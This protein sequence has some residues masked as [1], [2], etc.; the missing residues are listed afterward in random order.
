VSFIKFALWKTNLP[1]FEEEVT[2]VFDQYLSENNFSSNQ[3]RFLQIVKSILITKKHITYEDFYSDSFS[4]FWM[5][6]FERYFKAIEQ[7]QVMKLINRFSFEVQEEV[8][9]EGSFS[10]KLSIESSF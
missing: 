5:W 3:I 6:A 4:S 1:N 9:R 10:K 8:V 2:K 7:K